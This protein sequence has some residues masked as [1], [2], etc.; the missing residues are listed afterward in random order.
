MTLTGGASNPVVDDNQI[1][2]GGITLGTNLGAS[3]VQV[4]DNIIQAGSTGIDL[5]GDC[6]AARSPAMTTALLAPLSSSAAPFTGVIQANDFHGAQVGVIYN[7]GADVGNNRIFGN[8]VGVSSNVSAVT[9]GVTTSNLLANPGAETGNLTGWTVGGTSNPR[10][11][12]DTFDPSIHPHTGSYDFVG[13]TGASGTL[14]QTVQL[15][16]PQGLT[17]AAIDTGALTAN[18]S[19]WEQGLSQGSPSDDA[20]VKH[21]LP[22]RRG[23]GRSARSRP[24]KSMRT[25]APGS[26]TALASRSRSCSCHYLHHGFHPPQRQ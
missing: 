19:F 12:N 13:G 1:G 10:V 5:A 24:P 20:L 18:L 11:D 6:P 21:H 9:G 7:A 2:A 25:A 22:E 8:T 17:A 16:G 4:N 14:S 3:N 15:V 26:S 23:A